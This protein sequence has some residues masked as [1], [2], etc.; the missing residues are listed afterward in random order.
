M[1]GMPFSVGLELTNHCNLNCRQCA[2]G[3]GAITRPAGFMSDKVFERINDELSQYILN[4]MFY[5]QGESMMHPRFFE[6]IEMWKGKGIIISTNGHFLSAEQVVRL[7]SSPVRRVIVSM[8]GYSQ[9]VYADYRSGGDLGRV[10]EGLESLSEALKGR[11][12]RPILEVQFLVSRENEHEM[13][14][15]RSYAENIGARFRA[16][17]MQITDFSQAENLLPDSDSFRRY[18]F[19]GDRYWLRRKRKRGCFRLWTIPV[20]TWDGNVVPCCFDKNGDHIM[21]NIMQESFASIWNS[22]RYSGFREM[23]IS[24]SR[25]INMCNNCTDGLVR[26]VEV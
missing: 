19:D 25:D 4:T 23:V 16:K 6:L 24:G 3:M 13:G 9:D 18:T 1:F 14:L 17:S 21:G 5:F 22:K 26:G 20:I 7:A 2:R 10:K 8:D 15:V 11:R 12:N